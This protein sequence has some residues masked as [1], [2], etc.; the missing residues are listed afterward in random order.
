MRAEGQV[1]TDNTHITIDSVLSF[2]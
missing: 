2:H 1:S